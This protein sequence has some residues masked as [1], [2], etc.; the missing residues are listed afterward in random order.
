MYLNDNYFSVTNEEV[1][2]S[3]DAY[4]PEKSSA[5]VKKIIDELYMDGG[6]V[7]FG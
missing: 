3:L 4:R 7:N 2:K 1:W 5:T 6:E